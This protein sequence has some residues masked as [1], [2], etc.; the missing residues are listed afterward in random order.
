MLN[1]TTENVI[2]KIPN[3][4][5]KSL[6]SNVVTTIHTWQVPSYDNYFGYIG[7]NTS[8]QL[9]SPGFYFLKCGY[10]KA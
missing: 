5:S 10:Q 1:Y 9:F 3:E 8:L 4:D 7:L 2:T 6:L